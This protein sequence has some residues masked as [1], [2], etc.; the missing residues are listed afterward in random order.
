MNW[1]FLPAPQD[2]FE[3]EP[4]HAKSPSNTNGIKMN[5]GSGGVLGS[6]DRG[7]ERGKNAFLFYP[8][9]QFLLNPLHASFNSSSNCKT[10][11]NWR[12][13]GGL[14]NKERVVEI[15]LI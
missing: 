14:G 10:Y 3:W 15:H 11:K 7:R 9:T 1:S 6:V 5:F 8:L 2:E 13:K 4:T 12:V